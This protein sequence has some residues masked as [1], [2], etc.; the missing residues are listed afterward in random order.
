MKK[1]VCL[2]LVVLICIGL[3]ACSFDNLTAVT[4]A[5]TKQ[6]FLLYNDKIEK[7]ISKQNIKKHNMNSDNTNMSFSI[8]IEKNFLIYI[9]IENSTNNHSPGIE[10]VT[11]NYRHEHVAEQKSEE[12]NISLFVELVNCIS[13]KEIS[14]QE[15]LDFLN[16]SEN[17][18]SPEKYNLE[19]TKDQLVLK[20]NYLDFFQNWLLK[21]EQNSCNEETL[22]FWG[23]TKASTNNN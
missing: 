19:K 4:L 18:F 13:G 15:C 6:N 21:Y 17:E 2:F 12:F 10:R 7:L 20:I 14:V 5:E 22:T 1:L 8:Q 9:E 11:V 23:L 16:A 3:A